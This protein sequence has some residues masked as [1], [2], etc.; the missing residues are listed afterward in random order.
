LENS[1]DDRLYFLC[2]IFFFLF[3]SLINTQR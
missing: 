2:E 3:H 1:P